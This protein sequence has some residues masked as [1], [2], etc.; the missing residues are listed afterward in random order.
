MNRDENQQANVSVPGVKSVGIVAAVA[1][2]HVAAIGAFVLIQGC[3]GPARQPQVNVEAPPPPPMPPPVSPELTPRPMVHKPIY[4]PVPAPVES[5]V[6]SGSY[7]VQKGD[8]LSKI[9]KMNGVSTKALIDANGITDPNKIKVGQRLTIPGGSA[10]STPA[11]SKPKTSSV[12]TGKA[13][14]GEY[15]VVSGDSLSRIAARNGTSVS[16]LKQANG[17]KSDN[18]RIGQKLVIPGGSAKAASAPA[19]EQK[20]EALKASAAPAAPEPQ[21]PPAPEPT[22][23]PTSSAAPEELATADA[24]APAPTPS[25][26]EPMQYTVLSGDTLDEI[27]KLF[28]VSKDQIMKLNN[29]PSESA[30]KPGQTILIPP[31]EL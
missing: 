3:V 24:S 13:T 7:T 22:P 5:S 23:V 16:A 10:V 30:L 6:P 18:I 28:I 9:A 25:T 12:S 1:L 26:E 19:A 20:A 27:A 31:P 29:L 11:P 2:M 21:L 14:G 17:L 15:V 8:S 4:T